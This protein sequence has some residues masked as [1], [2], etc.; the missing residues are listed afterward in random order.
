MVPAVQ[1]SR[2]MALNLSK[3]AAQMFGVKFYSLFS[4]KKKKSSYK[5]NINLYQEPGK[6]G[7]VPGFCSL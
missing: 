6:P 3:P 5:H 4:C 2:E 7:L 1:P